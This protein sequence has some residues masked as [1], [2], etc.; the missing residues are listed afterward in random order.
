MRKR[1]KG[2]RAEARKKALKLYTGLENEKLLNDIDEAGRLLG[3]FMEKIVDIH[4]Q[5]KNW[6]TACLT[7]AIT[8]L[9]MTIKPAYREMVTFMAFIRSFEA[10]EESKKFRQLIDGLEA[11]IK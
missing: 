7:S 2:K 10:E 5:D 8:T 1:R 11:E 9:L 4:K 6:G 3:E